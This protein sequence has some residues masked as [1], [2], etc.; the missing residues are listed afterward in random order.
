[1]ME[2]LVSKSDLARELRVPPSRISKWIERGLPVRTD[3][4]LDLQRSFL[5]VLDNMPPCLGRSG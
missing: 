5:W 3:G 4:K 1:M 2:E